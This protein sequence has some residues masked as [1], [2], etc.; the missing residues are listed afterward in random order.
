MLKIALDLSRRLR[1]LCDRKRKPLPEPQPW[2]PNLEPL[3]GRS[4]SAEDLRKQTALDWNL[5]HEYTL[6]NNTPLHRSFAVNRDELILAWALLGDFMHMMFFP[7]S[8]LDAR[9]G[10][11][12][13]LSQNLQTRAPAIGRWAGTP[14]EQTCLQALFALQSSAAGVA[15]L[16]GIKMFMAPYMPGDTKKW[17]PPAIFHGY[18]GDAKKKIRKLDNFNTFFTLAE[19]LAPLA[20]PEPDADPSAAI[21]TFS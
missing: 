16:P 3:E 10:Y 14:F 9:E 11:P 5:E 20:S 7:P 6:L 13:N 15:Y 19:I 8:H 1:A 4:T 18:G 2:R 17:L 12:G 21:H